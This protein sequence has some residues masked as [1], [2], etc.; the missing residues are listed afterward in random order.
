MDLKL[1]KIQHKY[2]GYKQGLR[3]R[4]SAQAPLAEN[5]GQIGISQKI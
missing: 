1:N 5:E 3:K 4:S 2:R